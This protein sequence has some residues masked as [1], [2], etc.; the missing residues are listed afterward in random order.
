MD[1]IS[2][3]YS[4]TAKEEKDLPD[5]DYS[6][7]TDNSFAVFDGVPTWFQDPYPNPS[8]G[9]E[10]ARLAAEFITAFLDSHNDGLSDI[11]TAFKR[12]NEIVDQYNKQRGVTKET[13]NHRDKQYGA[14]VGSFGFVKNNLFYYG[15]LNDCGVMAFDKEKNR[16]LDI[17]SNGQ[18]VLK[19]FKKRGGEAGFD[20]SDPSEHVNFRTHIVNNPKASVDGEKISFGVMTGETV[21]EQFLRVG[22]YPIIPGSS[23]ILF[24]D[25]FIPFL[26]DKDFVD[27]LLSSSPKNE[28]EKFIDQKITQAEKFQKE[29]T[30]V[31]IRF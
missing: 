8:P 12:A 24:S 28:I 25:G 21:A 13:V 30:L 15:Q 1:V 22:V 11:V 4:G 20:A 14:A 7:I 31:M 5:E 23:I 6:C 26:Y 10:V 16:E 2:L 18:D 17:I 3:H 27:I 9:S 29:K 19:Y